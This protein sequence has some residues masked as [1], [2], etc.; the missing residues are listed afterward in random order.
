MRLLRA[1][2]GCRLCTVHNN[3]LREY[4]GIDRVRCKS[5]GPQRRIGDGCRGPFLCVSLRSPWPAG[6]QPRARHLPS[7]PHQQGAGAE[8]GAAGAASEGVGVRRSRAGPRLRARLSGHPP[9]L[10]A[11]WPRAGPPPATTGAATP[12]RVSTNGRFSS[13]HPRLSPGCSIY[14]LWSPPPPLQN[15]PPKSSPAPPFFT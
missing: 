4:T 9:G 15:L 10:R 14:S 1:G 5:G 6:P 11:Y 3:E 13:A 8:G 12:A 7:L 2:F